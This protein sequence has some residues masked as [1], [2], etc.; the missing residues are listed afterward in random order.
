MHP[1]HL[2]FIFE[3]VISAHCAHPFLRNLHNAHTRADI[4]PF[5][6]LLFL[7]DLSSL[8]RFCVISTTRTPVRTS[9]PVLRM[10]S[11]ALA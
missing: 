10:F 1:F 9:T 4:H 8:T 11:S 3:W 2:L 6:L 7:G 5:H